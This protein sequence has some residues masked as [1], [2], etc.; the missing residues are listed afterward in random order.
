MTVDLNAAATFLQANARLLERRRFAHLFEQGSAEP[1]VHLLR[2]YRNDDGGF[3][4]AIEP[5]M[6]APASQPVGVHTALEILREVGVHDDAMIETAGDF[7]A[8][9]TRADGGIPFVLE[10]A[11]PYPHAPWWQYS[12]SSS[13]IQTPANAAAL[14]RLGSRHPWLERASE[15][16]FRTIAELDL[17]G[18]ATQPGYALQFGVAFLNEVPDTDRAEAALDALAPALAPLAAA[19]PDPGAEVTSP[20]DLAPEPTSRSRRLFDEATI[21]RHLDAL[22]AAQQD[23]GG[24]RVSWPDWNAAAAIEWRGVATVNALRLLRANGRILTG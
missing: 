18:I 4:H 8:S 14:H 5:D 11:M 22:E 21:D 9:I 20:L 23:D 10:S 17:G 3:G 15:F 24:W 12:D 16:C 6:R 7:L 2:A 19:E 1:V 13:A